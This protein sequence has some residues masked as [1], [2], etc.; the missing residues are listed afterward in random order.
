[1]YILILIHFT[2]LQLAKQLRFSCMVLFKINFY[3]DKLI[4]YTY[5]L[6]LS[7][8]QSE[9]VNIFKNK[10]EFKLVYYVSPKNASSMKFMK[11]SVFNDNNTLDVYILYIIISMFRNLHYLDK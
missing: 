10:L 7:Q 3:P 6:V 5:V 2:K 1:M 4:L 8:N 11:N 9:L